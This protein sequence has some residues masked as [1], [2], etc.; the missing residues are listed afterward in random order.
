MKFTVFVTGIVALALFPTEGSAVQLDDV[1]AY[2]QLDSVP[3]QKE[4]KPVAKPVA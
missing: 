4:A 2:A 1:D 3:P